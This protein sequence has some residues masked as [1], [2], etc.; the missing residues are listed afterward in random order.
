M[1]KNKF[2]FF[3]RFIT[4]FV[5]IICVLSFFNIDAAA[6]YRPVYDFTGDARTDF[7]VITIPAG[8]G[9][10]LTWKFLRNPGLP[11]P[12]N[13][14]I[15]SFVFG[16]NGD[17]IASADFYGD[18]K[19]EVAIRRPTENMYYETLFPETSVAPVVYEPWGQAGD[20]FGRDGD[21]DGDGKD[22]ETVIRIT[23]NR[24]NWWYKGTTSGSR[25]VNFGATATGFSTFAFQGADFTGDGRDEFVICQVTSASGAARWYVGDSVT[26]APLFEVD[27]GNFNDDYLVNPDD[28]TGDGI[29]DIVIWRGATTTRSDA[30]YWFIR[31]TATGALVPPVKFGVQGITGGDVPLRGN[32]D[33]DQKA[34]IAVFRP[35]TRE[36]FWVNSSD[37]SLG[38]QQWGDAGDTP[39]PNFFTF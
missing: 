1:Q 6:A 22:D 10:P 17:T 28:Y 30:G 18:S 8:A 35:S 21:Y 11:G 20:N 5:L 9:S 32:Y 33:G 36:W 27:W 25:T 13:A 38:V 19:T 7:T 34:D 3:S 14:F 15:R 23:S 4:H 12:G 31:N 2:K 16:V 26:G 37:G 39:L 29:A 24:L